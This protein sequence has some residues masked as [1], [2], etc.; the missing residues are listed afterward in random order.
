MPLRPT[1]YRDEECKHENEGASGN[2]VPCIVISPYT[3]G[4][5][6]STRYSLYSLLRTTEAVLGLPPLGRASSGLGE[7]RNRI[8]R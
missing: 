8:W 7:E 3:H 6:D 5:R 2:Q 4:V 1:P